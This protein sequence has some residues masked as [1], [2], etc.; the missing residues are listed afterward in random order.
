MAWVK[1]E[2]EV[3]ENLTDSHDWRLC[4]HKCVYNYDDGTNERGYRFI[5]RRP[6]G[7]LQAARGQA[8]IPDKKTL[9]SL[10]DLATQEG[11]FDGEEG[12]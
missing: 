4:F 6:D 3:M 10:L 11:W 2:A 8:R 9:L 5:W 7:S 12:Q 1:I